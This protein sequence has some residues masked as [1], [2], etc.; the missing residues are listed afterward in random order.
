MDIKVAV[1]LLMSLIL[2]SAQIQIGEVIT[3]N[4]R[5][6]SLQDNNQKIYDTN[7]K[8]LLNDMVKRRFSRKR[9]RAFKNH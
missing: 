6:R 7:Q 1:L 3:K 4:A 8:D 9:N 5:E 2:S